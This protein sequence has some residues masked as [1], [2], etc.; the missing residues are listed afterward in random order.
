MNIQ[1]LIIDPQYDFA[2]P[3]GQLFVPNADKDAIRLAE[4][5]QRHLD[6]ISAIHVTLDSHHWFDIAHPAFWIN[7][8]GQHPQPFTVIDE[9]AVL[10]GLWH[11]TKPAHQAR[12]VSYV[13][14]LKQQSRYDLVIWPPHCLIGQRGH[15]IV[16]PIA[17]Q[18]NHWEMQQRHS[19]NYVLKGMNIWTEHYSALKADVPDP[20]DSGT[21]LNTA[22]ISALKH[23]DKILIAGQALSHCVANTVYDIAAFFEDVEMQK[24]VLIEDATSAVAGFEHLADEFMH[25]MSQRGMQVARTTDM[26][27]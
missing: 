13:Q 7:E 24:L 8:Q 14:A 26:L 21:H 1:F 25:T 20:E 17:Q 3:K 18:L 16:E 5:L 2:D 10:Q 4:M 11:A 19:V 6:D 15:T 23:A 12:A 9:Q 27:L 22:L